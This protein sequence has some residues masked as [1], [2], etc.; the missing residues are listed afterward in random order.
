MQCHGGEEI[1][2][3]DSDSDDNAALFGDDAM[4]RG[5]KIAFMSIFSSSSVGGSA[6]Q[7]RHGRRS[8]GT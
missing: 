6:S 4:D 5:V 8:S 3:P 7:R 2:D 1:E